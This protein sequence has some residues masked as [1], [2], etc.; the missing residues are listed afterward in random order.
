M[1]ITSIQENIHD[2][3]RRRIRRISGSIAPLRLES[4]AR[5]LSN[6]DFHIISAYQ[7]DLCVDHIS[8]TFTEK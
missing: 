7:R 3:S 4:T 5:F 8:D 2:S 1:A 6:R